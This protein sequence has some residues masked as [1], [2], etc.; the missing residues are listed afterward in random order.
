MRRYEL[1]LVLR[2]DVAGRSRRQAIIDRTT[3]QITAAGGQIVK[4][5]PWG[6]RRLA[7][8]I[9]RHREGSY[10]IVVFEAPSDAI[11][12][13]ERSLLITE[14]V[15]RHLVIRAERPARR[16]ARRRRRRPTRLDEPTSRPASRTRTKR[17]TAASG[18]TSPRAKRPRPRSTERADDDGVQ[19]DPD[20]RQPRARPRDALHAERPAGH[21]FSVAVNQST[22]N[23]Q[24]GEWIEATD[25]FRVS[26]W[27]DRAERAAENLRKGNRVF[28]EGRFRTREYEAND[29]QKRMS[30]DITADNVIG[31]D[32][33]D[34]RRRGTFAGAPAAAGGRCP[35]GRRRPLPTG[36]R[37]HRDRRP[38]LL[39]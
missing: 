17:T 11:V 4:V 33:R 7:Y 14:E 1:M 37:R 19:Q 32:K 13:L 21:E 6:R 30:L 16:A 28:V 35:G 9:D 8:P 18:S 31:L 38:S 3:R 34:A 36:R 15:L 12:E 2:P 26:V 10:H 24:T 39:N 22:K 20:H 23:Q 29:G 27:G 5:A 25:W